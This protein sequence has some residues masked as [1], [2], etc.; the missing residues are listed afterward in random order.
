MKKRPKILICT[1]LLSENRGGGA[2]VSRLLALALRDRGYQVSILTLCPNHIWNLPGINVYLHPSQLRIFCEFSKAEAVILQGNI[3]KLAWPLLLF[4]RKALL[5][6]HIPAPA[7]SGIKKFFQN[8]L[9]R[10]TQVCAVSQY[11]RTL[12]V[13]PECVKTVPNPYNSQ[14]FHAYPEIVRNQDLIYVGRFVEDKGV[15][16]LLQAFLLCFERYHVEHT[17]TLIGDV[18]ENPQLE[19]QLREVPFFQKH[20]RCIGSC[21]SEKVAM[22]IARH[23]EMVIPSLCDEA[24]GI[25]AL[26]ALACGSQ[27]LCSR[28]GG[29][30]EALGNLGRFFERGNV[31]ELAKCLA[32]PSV[33]HPDKKQ[34]EAHLTK[35]TPDTVAKIYLSLLKLPETITT[36][37]A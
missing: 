16:I 32:F 35:H 5:I 10:K 28:C 17:L 1:W 25:V 31:E 12:E 18:S 8:L 13:K 21:P 33:E 2:M 11:M 14:L 22:E 19:K 29:L 34:I 37:K 20:V 24:F 23:R 36:N 15:G 26:E 30:P 6:R 9:E 7:S 3:L 4:R 27:V